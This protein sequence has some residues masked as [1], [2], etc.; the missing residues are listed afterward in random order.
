MSG[1]TIL[2]PALCAAFIFLTTIN[3]F[4]QLKRSFTG[5]LLTNTPHPVMT[6][7]PLPTIF[8]R[9]RQPFRTYN[10]TLNNLSNLQSIQW[11]AANI[12]LYREIAPQYGSADPKNAMGGENRPTPRRISNA[13]IDEPITNFN[14]RGLSAFVYVWGQFLDH[15]M[16]LTPTGTK[17]S[18]PIQLPSDEKIFTE[19]IPFTRSEIFPGTGVNNPRQQ[20]NL[21]TAWIDA[22][23]VYGSDS[24]RA[25]W[26][27]TMKMGKMKTSS[28]NNLPYNTMDGQK[29]GA[30]DARAPDMAN[31][32]GHTAVVF[33]AG[34]IRASEHPGIAALHTLFIREH[35]KICDRL[36]LEGFINDEII[37]QMARKEV[38]A[39]IQAIT[40]Q[41]F[42]PAIGIK[43]NKYYGYRQSVR[44]DITNTFATAGYRIGHTMVA[45]DLLLI[46]NQ[47]NEI[48][49]GEL[50]LVDVFWTPE[51]LFTY[52]PE[53]FLKGFAAHT[54][55][56]TDTKINSV[57]RNF[58]FGSP[59][60]PVRFGIDLGSLNIQRGRD[61]GLPDYNTV[62][63]YYT[64]SRISSFSQITTNTVLA[65][66]LRGLY[67]TVDNIDLWTGILAEDHLPNTSVGRTMHEILR[68]QFEKLRDGDYYFYLNDPYLPT[69]T[70]NKIISTKF[71]D[72]LKRNTTLTNLQ[73][74]V[75]FTEECP[76]IGEERRMPDTSANEVIK[77]V[78]A[79][80]GIF[81]NPVLRE[82]NVTIGD[83]ETSSI[84]KI[85]SSQ[86][87]LL[88]TINLAAHQ[89]N[90]QIN[91]SDL[92]SGVYLINIYTGKEVRSFKF[93]KLNN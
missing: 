20:M 32:N 18:V 25:R 48:E 74:N 28:G 80:T 13:V 60:D 83:A 37:Y 54:Q 77:T 22:S 49:P 3:V 56:E 50:D 14:S 21:N 31:D 61:H 41:E 87:V 1:K 11:G 26:L 27:R 12:P 38:G 33:A 34:D 65:D 82:L 70:K 30:L 55:Y 78:K 67:G 71:S 15:D 7:A 68:T 43:L 17:E 4:A 47:C 66:S 6:N 23:M 51:V 69:R 59:N 19:A 62:R 29:T 76:G 89:D 91:L 39:L 93:I 9:I 90:M 73:A 16:S 75:F 46:D 84:I 42:L 58:L 53:A 40:Y 79:T 72:V 35:N 45:D 10:G 36:R 85:F 57:L 8:P 86:G 92:N 24:A 2:P 88:K 5:K 44:S 64:G 52:T 81:P 63:K